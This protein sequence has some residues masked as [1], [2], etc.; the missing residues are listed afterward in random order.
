MSWGFD[1]LMR[2]ILGHTIDKTVGIS[3]VR[4]DVVR[5]MTLFSDT[6]LANLEVI[7]TCRARGCRIATSGTMTARPRL[8]GASKVTNLPTIER[9]PWEMMKLRWRIIP[10]GAPE[11]TR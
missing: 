5:S 9:T 2:M 3:L 11:H 4:G 10:G 7:L 6:G 8:I 1:L